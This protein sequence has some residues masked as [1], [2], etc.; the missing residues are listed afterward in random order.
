MKLRS[1][2]SKENPPTTPYTGMAAVA[3]V[4]PPKEIPAALKEKVDTLHNSVQVLFVSKQIPWIIQAKMAEDGYVTMEDLAC[5]WVSAEKAREEGPKDLQFRDGENGFDKSNSD[6]S[7]MRLYQAV[8]QARSLLHSAKAS[9][10]SD[11]LTRPSTLMPSV[12]GSHWRRTGSTRL[13]NQSHVWNTR[14]VTA[15]SRNNSAI[16][17]KVRSAILLLSISS[18]PSRRRG[19]G[20]PR[21]TVSS[22]WMALKK[23]R[24]KRK[25]PILK[26]GAN[27][28]ACIWSFGTTS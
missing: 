26:P 21:V 8:V 4:R 11:G 18:Q 16:V 20:Q 12:T 13:A 27:W 9:S 19:S 23:R 17:P 5:R 3:P 15:S 10:L 24:R 1:S 6:F 14:E 22:Q 25:E 7:A 2:R 28:S